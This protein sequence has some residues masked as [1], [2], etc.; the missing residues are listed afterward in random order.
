MDVQNIIT[1]KLISVNEQLFS[2]PNGKEYNISNISFKG[3]T[4]TAQ[5]PVTVSN[6][7]SLKA[8][9]TVSVAWREYEGKVYF[10]VVGTPM[11]TVPTVEDFKALLAL[12][13]VEEAL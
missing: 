7:T 12:E 8:G 11:G 2:T 4:L 13:E 9:D 5:L 6:R 10:T 1:A 3:Q